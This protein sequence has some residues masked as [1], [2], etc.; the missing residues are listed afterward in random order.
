MAPTPASIAECLARAR[1][2]VLSDVERE[3]LNAA[4]DDDDDETPILDP[5]NPRNEA[6]ALSLLYAPRRDA[7]SSQQQRRRDGDD[8]LDALAASYVRRTGGPAPAEEEE[9][10]VTADEEGVDEATAALAAWALGE[11]ASQ[12]AAAPAVFS[13]SDGRGGRRSWRGLVATR[14]LAPGD[15]ALSLPLS[16]PQPRALAITYA[17]CRASDFG[18]ALAALG[19]EDEP[20]ALLFTMADRHDRDSPHA[21][22]W[23]ALPAEWLGTPL[24]DGVRDRAIEHALG[25]TPLGARCAAARKHLDDAFAAL[26]PQIAALVRAYP[27]HLKAAWFSRAS[28]SWAAELWYAYAMQLALPPTG[29]RPG[30]DAAAAAAVPALV[31]LASLANHSAWPHAVAY[32]DCAR[33]RGEQR[34]RVFRPLRKGEELTISYGPLANDELLLFY[35]FALEQ[36]PFEGRAVRM[37]AAAAAA[38]ER[39]G[40]AAAAAAAAARRAAHEAALARVERA[41]AG[42]VAGDGWNERE[43]AFFGQARVFLRGRVEAEAAAA[44]AE[45][46]GGR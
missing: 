18:R 45:G 44:A 40:V 19:L 22:F 6:A 36:N 28:F 26:A 38:D 39:G 4:D 29:A 3:E 14:D 35:G 30:A 10:S 15:V 25:G 23:R 43:R 46:G 27:Q 2:Q 17:S 42:S 37:A 12:S 20:L 1:R 32:S 8:E 31:P 41:L 33:T 11:G 5:I 7:A 9:N 21:P 24:G 13:S 34:V 16:A